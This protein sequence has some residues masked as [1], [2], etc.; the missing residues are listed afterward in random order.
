MKCFWCGGNI[1]S[2][3]PPEHCLQ[4]GRSTDIEYEIYV[5]EA[6]KKDH[7]NWWCTFKSGPK[8]HHKERKSYWD[9]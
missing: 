1:V 4:C 2:D 3:P 7:H 6:Q 8:A 9:D 5:K